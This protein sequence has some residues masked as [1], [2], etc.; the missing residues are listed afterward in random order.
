MS[1]QVYAFDASVRAAYLDADRG[2]FNGTSVFLC[3]HGH[4]ESPH[5]LRIG[6]LPRGWSLA[7]SMPPAARAR[8]YVCADYDE[9]IDHP[10]EMGRFWRGSFELRGVPHEFVVAG[11]LPGFDGER[12]LADTRRICETQMRFWHGRGQPPMPRYVFMLNALADG[13]GGLEHRGS[14][15]LVAARRDLPRRGVA[16]AGDGYVTLLGLISHEYFHTWNVKRLRP[17]DF[18]R[19]DLARENYTQLLWFFEGFTSYYDDLLLLRSGVID[20]PRYLRLLSKT[21]KGV[22]ATP[23]RQLQSVAAASFDAWVKYYRVEEN[24]PNAT[25]SYYTKGSLVALAFDLSLR[26]A[27]SVSLDDVMRLLWKRSAGGP[28]DETDILGA[29]ESVAGRPMAPLLADWVH[30]TGELP[31]KA[32]LAQAGVDWGDEAS[33]LAAEIG[34]RLS[35]GPVTG[36]QVRSVHRGSAAERAGIAAG[37]ELLAVDGWRVR[38]LDEARAWLSPGQPFE[39][40]LVRDQR[41]LTR[42]VSP[43]AGAQRNPALQLAA[44]CAPAAHALRRGWIGV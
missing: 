20:A 17:R 4:E 25:V 43:V 32:L 9:L 18:E 41:V 16:E 31:L 39:L 44:T 35:E 1:Y 27:G 15:A 42:R 37:D 8:E 22:A 19:F 11:A 5:R 6:A 28:V 34:L 23:G 3:A 33:D 12:L 7:T 10:V 24:T 38:R 30:G 29:L 36:V 26:A 2:F 13:Y 14:T 21:I 40:L